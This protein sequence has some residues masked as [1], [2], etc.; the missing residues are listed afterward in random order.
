[1]TSS[2]QSPVLARVSPAPP[3]T[4]PSTSWATP[5][6]SG[7]ACVTRPPSWNRSRVGSL[8]DAGL[9][10]GI[11]V[12]DVGAGF[13]DVSLLAASL[14][15]PGGSVIGVERDVAAVSTATERADELG[16]DGVSFVAGDIRDV[17]LDGLVERRSAVRADVRTIRRRSDC[18]GTP[19]T[20]CP[21]QRLLEPG[22]G[23]PVIGCWLYRRRTT[24]RSASNQ[25]DGQAGSPGVRTLENVERFPD[26]RDVDLETE[27]TSALVACRTSSPTIESAMESSD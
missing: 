5:M 1:M 19:N 12:L 9:R 14:V 2:P 17:E 23:Q 24:G 3:T 4:T 22:P 6:S 10:R 27:G 21:V 25:H 7:D 11:R 13:G 26:V 15:A 18:L 20:T 8:V 16:A